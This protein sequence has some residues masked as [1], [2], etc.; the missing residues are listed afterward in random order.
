MTQHGPTKDSVVHW[1]RIIGLHQASLRYA[2]EP[3]DCFTLTNAGR[4]ITNRLEQDN[5]RDEPPS[6]ET[7]T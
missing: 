7:I 1:T 2:F 6:V 4:A 3:Q 5:A